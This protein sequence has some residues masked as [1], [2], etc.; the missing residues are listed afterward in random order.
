MIWA[1]SFDVD[2]QRDLQ[3]G[4][5]FELLYER[6]LDETGLEVRSGNVL[7]AEIVLRG[8]PVR[9]YR[10]ET[11]RAPATSSTRMASRSASP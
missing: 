5:T 11:P 6:F 8:K 2:F 7:Y 10:H 9:F 1:L 3:Q 4:D